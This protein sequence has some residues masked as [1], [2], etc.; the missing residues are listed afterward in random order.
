MPNAT[1]STGITS[2]ESREFDTVAPAPDAGHWS[3]PRTGGPTKF[4]F[5]SSSVPPSHDR[6]NCIPGPGGW[7]DRT[8]G[9]SSAWSPAWRQ[10]GKEPTCPHRGRDSGERSRAQDALS[11]RYRPPLRSPRSLQVHSAAGSPLRSRWPRRPCLS[12][13]NIG[14]S[15]VRRLAEPHDGAPAQAVTQIARDFEVAILY[16]YPEC[17]GRRRLPCLGR[18]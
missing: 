18:P 10:I 13:Y 14:P 4:V 5:V 6:H 17:G 3:R 16:G 12:G 7:P 8:I 15:A 2:E 1:A 11:G 9:Q